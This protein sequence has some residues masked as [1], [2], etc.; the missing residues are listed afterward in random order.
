[1]E[2]LTRDNSSDKNSQYKSTFSKA[3]F[4]IFLSENVVVPKDQ[5]Y[6]INPSLLGFLRESNGK[7]KTYN[8]N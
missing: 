3:K 2:F 5:H 1:M 7:A 8:T 4:L 6:S